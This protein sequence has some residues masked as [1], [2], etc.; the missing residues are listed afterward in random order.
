[1]RFRAHRRTEKECPVPCSRSLHGRAD[2]AGILFATANAPLTFQRTL[3]PRA[4]V[5][6]ALIT[7]L[8]ASTNHALVSLMQDEIQAAALVVVGAAA[9][10]HPSTSG[11][12]AAPRSPPTS[13]RSASGVAIQRALRQ[14]HREP[15]PRAA[16]RTGG[17]LARGH[18]HGGRASS[19]PV[20]ESYDARGRNRRAGRSRSCGRPRP[21]SPAPTRGSSAAARTSTPT[22]RPR[23]RGVARRSRSASGSASRPPCRRSAR[24]ERKL[25][26]VVSRRGACAPRQRGNVAAARARGR[27]RRASARRRRY[28]AVNVMHR[29]EHVQ[30]SAEAA[31][32][33]PPPNPL[34]SGSLES[35]VR[36]TRSRVQAA[37]SCG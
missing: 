27:A 28:V 15:L 19:A 23:R 9:A 21:R 3:M 36:S 24:A 1:M 10:T 4:L 34:L 29:I 26:D 11:A 2:Q 7:G 16:I 6:Q 14:R 12:G 8:S 37:A 17:L 33:I 22:C 18:R 13:R 5:D 35:L 25:A 20:Q 31:F 30:E 32:D